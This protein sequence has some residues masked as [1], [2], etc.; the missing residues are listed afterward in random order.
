MSH[1][2][3]QAHLQQVRD[4]RCVKQKKVIWTESTCVEH[5]DLSTK[6]TILFCSHRLPCEQKGNTLSRCLC[7]GQTLCYCQTTRGSMGAT[8]CGSRCAEAVSSTTRP[9]SSA[10]N[11]NQQLIRYYLLQVPEERWPKK[12]TILFPLHSNYCSTGWGQMR[13]VA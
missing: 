13:Q 6:Y 5:K 1:W 9:L 8:A 7:T 3:P 10:A 2:S 12:P 11:T 4:T